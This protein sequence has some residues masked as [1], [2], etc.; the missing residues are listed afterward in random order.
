MKKVTS[1]PAALVLLGLAGCSAAF[2][3]RAD[4]SP[5]PPIEQCAAFG[6]SVEVRGI[7]ARAPMCV[8]R[9]RDANRPCI[10]SS[11]C[12][13][14]CLLSDTAVVELPRAGTRAV[15]YCEPDN[16]TFGCFAEVRRGKAT[17]FLCAE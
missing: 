1:W 3:A 5:H 2:F 8:I 6:G 16:A 14:R 17:D 11:Q 13:G 7:F 10:D 12:R 15:G 9:N 4:E